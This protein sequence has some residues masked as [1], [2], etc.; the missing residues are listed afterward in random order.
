MVD[1][2]EQRAVAGF[3][4]AVSIGVLDFDGATTNIAVYIK[5]NGTDNVNLKGFSVE[6]Y[7]K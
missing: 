4:N 1:Y 6:H 7:I 3:E 2:Q 5:G